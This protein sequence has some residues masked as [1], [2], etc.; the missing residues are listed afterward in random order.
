MSHLL[1]FMTSMTSF[2]RAAR[3]ISSSDPCSCAYRLEQLYSEEGDG[4][5][6]GG[7][8]MEGGRRREEE[9]RGGDERSLRYWVAMVRVPLQCR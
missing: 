1:N 4:G 7:R 6:E 9:E 8:E 5:R 3:R 2:R